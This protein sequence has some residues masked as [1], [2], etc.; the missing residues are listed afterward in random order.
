MH[1]CLQMIVPLVVL[2]ELD[3]FVTSEVF[4]APWLQQANLQALK[5]KPML[6]FTLNT[7]VQLL[8]LINHPNLPIH[9]S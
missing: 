8:T 2:G 5:I 6:H 9:V 3:L 7:A 4:A 1:G